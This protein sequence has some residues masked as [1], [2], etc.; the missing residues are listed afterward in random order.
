MRKCF[1]NAKFGAVTAH[2]ST[3]ERVYAVQAFIRWKTTF[4]GIS[5]IVSVAS[6]DCIEKQS[7]V[8][9]WGD[10]SSTKKNITE[11]LSLPISERE[12]VRKN[13]SES[14]KPNL[15]F[16]WQVMYMQWPHY[17]LSEIQMSQVS[18]IVHIE[19]SVLEE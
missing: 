4:E 6:L 19:S 3:I 10:Q 1:Y 5:S 13:G 16:K 12:T 14:K 8:V 15:S 7:G 11:L 9:S 18:V 17:L 2:T